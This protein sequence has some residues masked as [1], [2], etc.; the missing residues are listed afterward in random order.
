MH[1]ISGRARGRGVCER[2]IYGVMESCSA[3]RLYGVD[4]VSVSDTEEPGPQQLEGAEDIKAQDGNGSV[5]RRDP[6]KSFRS[7]SKYGRGSDSFGV[8]CDK[9][10][11]GQA[12]PDQEKDVH[13]PIL[14]R[15]KHQGNCGGIRLFLC[16]GR[17]NTEQNG[18]GNNEGGT[19]KRMVKGASLFGVILVLLMLV[20][21]GRT[22]SVNDVAAIEPDYYTVHKDTN[23]NDDYYSNQ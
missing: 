12:K 22:I 23:W 14:V 5:F 19:M 4:E 18:K 3:G 2:R 8:G 13:A 1:R 21:S 6:C 11:F 9:P 10:L 20:W 7:G 17:E 15:E 16:E